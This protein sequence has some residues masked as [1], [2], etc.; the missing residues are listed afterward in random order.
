MSNKLLCQNW[1][2]HIT[3][4]QMHFEAAAQYRLSQEELEKSRYGTEVARLKVA[5]GLAKKGLDVGKKGVAESVVSDLRVI[6]LLLM[7]RSSADSTSD[8]AGGR[9]IRL[10]AS[11]TG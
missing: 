7:R 10:R 5:E 11:C 2:S 9:E 3:V 4:K 6:P 1:T 8:A